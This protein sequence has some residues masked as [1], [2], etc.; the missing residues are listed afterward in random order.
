MDY[1]SFI[2]K[3]ARSANVGELLKQYDNGN[4][5]TYSKDEVS[6]FLSDNLTWGA[7]AM[8]KPFGGAGAVIGEL[9]YDGDGSLSEQEIDKFLQNNYGLDLATIKDYSVEEVCAAIQNVEQGKDSGLEPHKDKPEDDIHNDDN[10][11]QG[12]FFDGLKDFTKG[13]INKGFGALNGILSFGAGLIGAIFAPK[14]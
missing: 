4:D 13:L 11:P 12:N 2:N 9:D 5:Q 8:L 1:L 7:N 10:K 3:D 14:D 6:A